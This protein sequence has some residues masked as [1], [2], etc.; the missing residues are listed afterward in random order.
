MRLAL[1]AALAVAAAGA[2]AAERLA[3]EQAPDALRPWVPWVLRGHEE[4]LCPALAGGDERA[5]VWPGALALDLDAGGGRFSQTLRVDQAAFAALPGDRERWP[6]DVRVGERAAAVVEREGRPALRLE[7]GLHEV[8]GSF[9]WPSLPA[10]LP[11]PA[12]TGLVSLRLEG[13]EVALPKRDEEGR[14]WLRGRSEDPGP[15]ERRIELEV[16]RKLTDEVPLLLETRIVVR[17]S[18]PPREEVL[19]PP[20]PAGFAPLRLE[21]PLPARLEPGGALRV[22]V[23]PGRFEIVLDARSEGRPGDVSPPGEAGRAGPWAASEVWVFEARPALRLVTPEGVAVD[24]QQTTLPGEWRSL[25]AFRMDAGS[26]LRLVE[27]RRGAAEPA[28]ESLSLVRTWYLDFEGDGATVSDRIEGTLRAGTRLEM[29]EG[30]DLGRAAVNGTDQFVTRRAGSP[31]A[32][33]QLPPGP[34]AVDADSRVEG[35]PASLPVV[36]WERDFASVSASLELP[37]GWRLLHAG[38]VDRAQWTWWNRWTL[39]DLFFALVA[40]VAFLRLYGPAAG[41]LAA[42]ALALTYTEPGAPRIAWL[43]VLAAEALRRG[44]PAGR[45]ARAVLVARALALAALVAVAV[46]FAVAAL[47]AGLYPAL[48]PP[49]AGPVAFPAATMAAPEAQDEAFS[50]AGSAEEKSLRERVLR[51]TRAQPAAPP[52]DADAGAEEPWLSRPDPDARI[53]TGPGVPSWSWGRVELSWSGPVER[54]RALRLVLLPPAANA[55]LAVVRVVLVAALLALLLRGLRA[56]GGGRSGAEPAAPV[57]PGRPA[58]PAGGTAPAPGEA[59]G[60]GASL[61]RFAALAL[62]LALLAAGPARAEFPPPELLDELRARLLDAPACHP[63]CVSIPRLRLEARA[64]ALRLELVVEAA[65][66]VALPLPG[67]AASWL[68]AEVRLDGEP[69]RALRRGADGTLWLR[70]EPGSHAVALAGPLPPGASVAIPLP[71]VP[72][73]AEAVVDGY[74]LLGLRPDGGAEATLQLVRVAAEP[75]EPGQ[76]AVALPPFLRVE[77]TL[78]LGLTWEAQVRVLRLSPPDEALVVEVPLLPGESVT[79]PG[80]EVRGGRVRVALAPGASRA[81]WTSALAVTDSLELA[82]PEGVP[83]SEA[84]SVRASP[85]WH[86]SPEGIPPVHADPSR[87]GPTFAW[88][89]WP[90]EAVRLG[91]ERP[92]GVGGATRTLDASR[93]ALR[94]GA[95]SSDAELALTLRSSQGGEQRVTLPEGAELQRVAVDGRE[96][97]IRQEGRAVVVPLAPGS[98]VVE[99]AWREP[100]GLA[101]RWRGP[102]VDVGVPGVNAEVEVTPA[103]GRWLLFASGPSLGPAVLFWPLLVVYLAIAVVLG[104]TRIAPLRT[105]QWLL[106]A[107]GLTQVGVVWAASVPLWLLA[108]GWRRRHGGRIPGRWLDLAQLGLVLLTL[109]ALA[110]LLASIRAGLLGLPE[111]QVAGNG[112]SAELLRW[113]QDR[114]RGPLPQPALLSVPLFVYRALM[115]AWALWIAQALVGW[116][117][118][119]WS[120]ASTGE[121]WRPLR[122]P[123]RDLEGPMGG[124]P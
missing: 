37:P 106:L 12:E 44:V 79:T 21:S 70:V 121:L 55:L 29:G 84:W 33:I 28:P 100:R 103:T 90:G 51:S 75:E 27:R 41:A 1:A 53:T 88:R 26:S 92:Q 108:L 11:V 77:R 52:G 2:A 54:G 93:L 56:T 32:G 24:P 42:F 7:P 119:G 105:H 83:W 102:E 117:R 16:S 95:H 64:G 14:L 98:V 48:V 87:A 57:G 116:L 96:Q 40:T 18:G 25:P 71:L 10:V 73:R 50:S 63:E 111:M 115:L 58:G 65:A 74:E 30:T 101:A 9:R 69:A 99:L 72:H 86:L 97:P 68:A 6:E 67:N 49:R 43:A 104:G 78:S 113:Y 22:Q 59:G 31:R 110:A 47:R 39:L 62:A 94:P 35:A 15:G 8:R 122:R 46:P 17:V 82:A 4:S 114:T 66:Q 89:P 85:I 34:L 120:A 3:P 76:A 13:R 124:T 107:V 80:L 123:R 23:R 91:V 19:G 112:S 38:G 5:C 36:S 81:G 61:S 60:Q 20:L 118:F 109:A 45:F